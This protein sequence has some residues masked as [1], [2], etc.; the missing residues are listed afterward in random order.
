MV[1][2]ATSAVCQDNNDPATCFQTGT[3]FCPEAINSRFSLRTADIESAKI[4]KL[5]EIARKNVFALIASAGNS[6]ATC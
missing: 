2:P 6:L 1:T 4:G 5:L 3:A